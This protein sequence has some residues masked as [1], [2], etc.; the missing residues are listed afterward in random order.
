VFESL[1]LKELRRKKDKKLFVPPCID[2]KFARIFVIF[3]IHVTDTQSFH[4]QDLTQAAPSAAQRNQINFHMCPRFLLTMTYALQ[5]P[6]FQNIPSLILALGFI[7]WR[8]L[9]WHF[10]ARCGLRAEVSLISPTMHQ[11]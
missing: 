11:R 1:D 7:F 10:I 2:S 3:C 8:Y 4:F 9:L 5:P 6:L